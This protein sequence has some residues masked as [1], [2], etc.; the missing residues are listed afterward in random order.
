MQDTLCR[1]AQGVNFIYYCIFCKFSVTASPLPR[2]PISVRAA[3]T[4][5]LAFS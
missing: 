2:Y 3:N 5:Y 4:T 1:I